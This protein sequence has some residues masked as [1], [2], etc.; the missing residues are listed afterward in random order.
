MSGCLSLLSA[1][2]IGV[3]IKICVCV[4]GVVVGVGGQGVE[5]RAFYKLGMKF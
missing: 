4:G 3:W 5:L 1:E 2:I